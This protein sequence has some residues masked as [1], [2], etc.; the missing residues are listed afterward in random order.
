MIFGDIDAGTFN[1]APGSVCTAC[2]PGNYS[3]SGATA[4]IVCPMGT[5]CP[6]MGTPAP[7]VCPSGVYGNN[8]GMYEVF[9]ISA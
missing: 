9:F 1:A 8:S 7:I 2:S 3:N 5:F 4:C 6:D